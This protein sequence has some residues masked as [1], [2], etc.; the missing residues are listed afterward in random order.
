MFPFDYLAEPVFIR[1]AGAVGNRT[2]R[3]IRKL[4]GIGVVWSGIGIL[5]YRHRPVG[6]ISESRH[7]LLILPVRQN[8]YVYEPPLTP[9]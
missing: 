2:Y 3:N 5:S 4:E 9:P 8:L 6:A 7:G 1:S